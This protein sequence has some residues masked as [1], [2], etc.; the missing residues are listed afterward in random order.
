MPYSAHA[1]ANSSGAEAPSRKLKAERAWSSVYINRKAHAQTSLDA[2]CRN[3]SDTHP[4]AATNLCFVCSA[5]AASRTQWPGPIH[6]GTK[7]L[8][9]TNLR[10][11]AM[12]RKPRRLFP[13]RL[14]NKCAQAV[15]RLAQHSPE[16]LVEGCETRRVAQTF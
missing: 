14:A 9:A 2:Q 13:V 1:A 10:N 11:S 16:A 8:L 7:R 6:P 5:H 3:K 15:R 12:V 4:A